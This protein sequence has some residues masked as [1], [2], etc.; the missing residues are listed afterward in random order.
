MDRGLST[1]FV[2][3]QRQQLDAKPAASKAINDLQRDQIKKSSC[4]YFICNAINIITT[5]FS[6]FITLKVVDGF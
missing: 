1:E 3:Y 5:A 4:K 6:D 2:W